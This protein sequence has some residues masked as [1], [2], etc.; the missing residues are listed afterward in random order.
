MGGR[1]ASMVADELHAGGKIAGLVCLGYPFHPP[2]RPEQLRT[3]HLA[4]PRDADADLPGHARRVRHARRRR[5]LRAVAAHRGSL[6]RGRRPRPQAAQGVSGFSA[7]DHLSAVAREVAAGPRRGS[8]SAPMKIATFNINNVNKRPANLLDWL[9]RPQPDVVCLQELKATRRAVSRARRSR[10]AGYG[11]VWRGQSTWNGVAILARGAEPVLTRGDL[12]GDAGDSQSRYIEAAVGGVLSPAL[13]AERQPAAR[14]EIRLQARLAR[15]AA[16]RMRPSFLRP[17]CRWCSPAITTSC[18]SRA[19]STRPNP[20]TTNA[21]V[22]P[23]SRAAFAACSTQGWT[24]AIRKLHPDAHLHL[25]GLYAQPLAARCRPAPRPSAAQPAGGA[26]P[27]GRRRRPRGARPRRRQRPRADL[28]RT[29]LT[30]SS[31]TAYTLRLLW[32]YWSATTAA[33]MMM[34]LTISW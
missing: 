22:Q 25:L 26:A 18:P 11:A 3:K 1:V 2:G 23:E 31:P 16:C 28:D 30:Q 5:R 10:R 6:A 12:P 7:A 19:T 8:I 33:T 4:E 24:D 17:A 34:P 14:P 27:E 9:A 21:L 15:A 32:R 29:R 20:M 13:R